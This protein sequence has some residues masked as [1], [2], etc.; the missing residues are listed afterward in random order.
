[1]NHRISKYSWHKC[2][3]LV[4]ANF[5]INKCTVEVVD[6]YRFYADYEAEEGGILHLKILG[7]IYFKHTV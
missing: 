4:C 2:L 1:M 7:I 5:D 6:L 3:L